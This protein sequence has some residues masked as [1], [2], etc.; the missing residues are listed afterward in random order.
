MS[1]HSF[2]KRLSENAFFVVLLLALG[3]IGVQVWQFRAGSRRAQYAEAI[4]RT[5]MLKD[6]FLRVGANSPIEDK[7][8]FAGLAYFAPDPAYRYQLGYQPEP[9]GSSVWLG[10]T[11]GAR[12]PYLRAG[13][14]ILEVRGYKR[15]VYLFKALG[16]GAG[17]QLLLPFADSTSGNSTY[18]VGR[19]LDV[20]PPQGGTVELDFNQAYHPY[21]AY[22]DE[23]ACPIPP[24]ENRL[25]VGIYAGERIK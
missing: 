9:E 24:P 4:Q 10:S 11:K 21:C 16:P 6:S 25:Q 1:A 3:L 5:R 13:S 19:Y 17:N 18:V 7:A 23:Y 22:S 15:Q 12:Q 8:D 2:K 20:A 14:A